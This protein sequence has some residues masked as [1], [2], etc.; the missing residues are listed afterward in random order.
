MKVLFLS[1]FF[2][3]LLAASP[4]GW[5]ERDLS[6]LLEAIDDPLLNY[7]HFDYNGTTIRSCLLESERNCTQEPKIVKIATETYLALCRDTDRGMIDWKAF[8]KLK[9][10]TNKTSLIW[11]WRK[12]R[13]P[14]KKRLAKALHRHKIHDSLKDLLPRDP[15]YAMLVSA[16]R[17]MAEIVDVGGF[18]KV[19]YDKEGK[20]LRVG[21]RGRRV[22]ELKAYLA[23]TGDLNQTS[24]AYLKDPFFDENL[25]R[26]LIRFQKRHYLKKRGELD[27][28][29]V[30][31]TRITAEEKLRKIALNIERFKCFKPIVSRT[32]L[33]V[34]IP[35]F[36]L[37]FYE[38][39]S[40]TAD[41]FVVVGRE[42]RPTPIFDDRLEYIVL[43]PTWSVPQNLLRKD[44]LPKL[45]ENPHALDGMF[46]FY[47]DGRKIDPNRI[48]WKRY[49]ERGRTVPVRLMQP[50]GEKNVLGRMK[51][52]FPN[53]Y[54]VYLHDT[55]AKK[56]TD[57]RYRLYS[58][59]CIRLHEP[60][61]LLSL[62]APY[63]RLSYD[64]MLEIIESNKTVRVSL[65]RKIPIHIRYFTAFVDES[66][67]L[68]FRRDF[69]GY[70]ALQP[71]L[72]P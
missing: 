34:N 5:K 23:A 57:D 13:H 60:Y 37:K 38:E 54:H 31:Y 40:L 7:R 71:L 4:S 70:D 52:I 3:T 16:Y 45:A 42:D 9:K 47:L 48:E 25:R 21:E 51:F 65:K 56:L 8:E 35:A 24:S 22:V 20:T 36:S 58:S 44:Y 2:A 27:N 29:T 11:E 26:A 30:L 62:L 14:C 53:R 69:Y 32:Y 28:V 6:D 10:D 46:D 61:R 1:L 17:K 41:I 43:N 63:T 67:K 59:G 12:K 19:S 72:L 18:P 64:R 55:D 49:L 39:G 50:S 66:G 15:G 68:N 33:L